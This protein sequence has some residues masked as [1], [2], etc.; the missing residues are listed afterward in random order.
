MRSCSDASTPGRALRRR[1]QRL[2]GGLSRGYVGA[3]G[4]TARA[5]RPV[6]PR[7]VRKQLRTRLVSSPAKQATLRT[8]A[9]V[10]ASA[11]A[12]SGRRRSPTVRNGGYVGMQYK[13]V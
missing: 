8:K 4:R 11:C 9:L 3:Y 10:A 5:P 7:A 12:A 1:A 2:C 6:Y 13:C